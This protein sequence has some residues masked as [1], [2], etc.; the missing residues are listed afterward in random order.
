MKINITDFIEKQRLKLNEQWTSL[1]PKP[2]QDSLSDYFIENSLEKLIR[3]YEDLD[4]S[5]KYRSES[6]VGY[7][8]ELNAESL[9]EKIKDTD[10]A[11][12]N[13]EYGCAKWHYLQ[14][15]LAG[16]KFVESAIKQEQQEV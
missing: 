10:R 9:Y 15:M 14:G 1:F 6:F 12:Y 11:T 7:A 8:L 13:C 16:L 3:R 5:L 2:P 4:R